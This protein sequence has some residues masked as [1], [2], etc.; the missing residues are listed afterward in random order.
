MRVIN[1]FMKRKNIDFKLQS[2]VRG[3]LD[4]ILK[5]S[6]FGSSEKEQDLISRL[7]NTL[8]RELLLQANGNIL[9]KSPV[10][11]K[12]FSL[13]TIQKLTELMVP[14]DLAPEDYVY[15]VNK[16]FSFINPLLI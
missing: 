15:E 9:M 7:S 5:E 8:R 16:F 14:L 11:T 4:Y 1:R 2:K 6:D 12:N 3:Y 10:L 13:K